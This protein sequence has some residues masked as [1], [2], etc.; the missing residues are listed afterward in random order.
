MNCK[1][2]MLSGVISVGLISC[3]KEW[4]SPSGGSLASITVGNVSQ[5]KITYENTNVV[6][7]KGGSTQQFSSAAQLASAK[8]KAGDNIVLSIQLLRLGKVVAESQAGS[9]KCA[10]V[11]LKLA[12]GKNRVKVPICLK[13]GSNSDP[14]IVD[15][16]SANAD[17]SAE[18][19]IADQE[20]CVDNSGGGSGAPYGPGVPS[21]TANFPGKCLAESAIFKSAAG[22][23]QFQESGLVFS[24]K[25]NFNGV[26]KGVTKEAAVAYC[27]ILNE[28]GYSDWT[29]PTQDQLFSIKGRKPGIILSKI[30]GSSG[31]DF[32]TASSMV[33]WA[34]TPETLRVAVRIYENDVKLNEYFT[35][36][37]QTDA[38]SVFC[39]RN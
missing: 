27:D 14:I 36:Y 2:L 26:F 23:C 8:F 38:A 22:G 25:S 19:C 3:K 30:E 6:V 18:P 13:D 34:G 29:L 4:T 20:G 32:W 11:S 37:Q 28:G 12:G 31:E 10:P 9:T 21:S 33:G 5:D 7:E 16:G 39:V 24:L 35:G 1:I 17:V 15:P